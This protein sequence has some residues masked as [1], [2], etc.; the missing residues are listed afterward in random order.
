MCHEVRLNISIHP[1]SGPE[2]P[3]RSNTIEST[4]TTLR[5]DPTLFICVLWMV[6]SHL[7]K[8]HKLWEW[9]DDVC[10]AFES[11]QECIGAWIQQHRAGAGEVKSFLA[12]KKGEDES[13]LRRSTPT[14][15]PMYHLIC[16]DTPVR[17]NGLRTTQSDGSAIRLCTGNSSLSSSSRSNS[18]P[19]A[20]T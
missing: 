19:P 11:Y 9:R 16:L 13:E 17:K 14:I 12:G 10:F 7:R 4:T 20:P 15:F 6:R 8:P 1:S 2:N 3:A 5:M 18:T